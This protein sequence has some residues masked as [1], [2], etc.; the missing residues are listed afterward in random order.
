MEVINGWN[1]ER[2][3]PVEVPP[4]S[5]DSPESM[6]EPDD[7]DTSLLG[8]LAVAVTIIL[9]VSFLGVKMLHQY[10]VASELDKAG[11]NYKSGGIAPSYRTIK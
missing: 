3:V 7:P 2:E 4:P 1:I 10:T 8:K 5:P 6:V 11:Y 9:V